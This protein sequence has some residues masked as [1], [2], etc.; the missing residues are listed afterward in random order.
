MTG[1]RVRR[2]S[3][4]D[5]P[6]ADAQRGARRQPCRACGVHGTADH[7]AMATGIFVRAPAR[8]GIGPASRSV[9]EQSH[10]GH[11]VSRNAD[12]RH[13]DLAAQIA[14]R[15]Q[16]MRRFLAEEG[17]GQPRLDRTPTVVRARRQ[18]LPL[19]PATPLGTSMATIGTPLQFA[20]T[21]HV[22]RRAVQRAR[23]A[24][25]EQRIDDQLRAVQRVGRQG[26][27]RAA[28]VAPPLRRRR[29]AVRPA[30]P[31]GRRSPAPPAAA[32]RQSRRRHCCRDRT[33]TT[34]AQGAK[35]AAMASAT[36]R[37]AFSIS[38]SEGVP[39][40][41]AKA[42]ARAICSTAENFAAYRHS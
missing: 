29:P 15:Q 2:R 1:D 18:D 37:P 24:R 11:R 32:P 33:D 34:V 41:T 14:S 19:S 5:Q 26:Q 42:S 22:A 10:T 13:N 30:A 16:Q 8:P 23:Q 31:P 17:D 36:A 27:A 7:Q 39:E 20:A 21:H 4:A 25:A 6:C 38:V 28:P 35:R 40:A 9:L 12:I 3:D